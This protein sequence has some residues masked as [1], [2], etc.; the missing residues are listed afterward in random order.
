MRLSQVKAFVKIARYILDEKEYDDYITY[1][2]DNS[3]SPDDIGGKE[4][5]Q[6]VYAQALISLDLKFERLY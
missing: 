1:C 2:S 5:Q 6:H 4:Q 3:I